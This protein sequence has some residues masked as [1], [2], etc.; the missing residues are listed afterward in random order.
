MSATREAVRRFE[1]LQKS[2]SVT[3]VPRP[4]PKVAKLQGRQIKTLA[5][6]IIETIL[7]G[8]LEKIP[9]IVQSCQKPKEDDICTAFQKSCSL[10][11][12]PASGMLLGEA[13]ALKV[14]SRCIDQ[15]CQG[16]ERA[17]TEE[18]LADNTP[19]DV[20]KNLLKD[21]VAG[22]KL[23]LI[24]FLIKTHRNL[25]QTDAKLAQE[26]LTLA[27]GQKCI[28]VI[29]LL[30]D[31]GASVT[32]SDSEGKQPLEVAV[33]SGELA[34]VTFVCQKGA[35]VRW[36][37]PKTGQTAM[38][39]AAHSGFHQAIL[40][41]A[42]CRANV[43]ELD[44]EGKSALYVA[45]AA[46][47]KEAVIALIEA[48]ADI[49]NADSQGGVTRGQTPFLLALEKGNDLIIDALFN[50]GRLD[51]NKCDGKGTTPLIGAAKVGNAKICSK[52]GQ[53]EAAVNRR[54]S[55]G[56]TALYWAVLNGHAQVVKEL[57]QLGADPNIADQNGQFPLLC[58]K[59]AA[60][61]EQLLQ[62]KTIEIDKID[63][64]GITALLQAT[65]K[66][67]VDIVRL[68]VAASAN[69]RKVC[70]GR[71]AVTPYFLAER[72]EN[73]EIL[74]IFKNADLQA[75]AETIKG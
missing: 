3:H 2:T 31:N 15:A 74:A 23:G 48:G 40:H 44:K 34:V 61:V 71:L 52:L 27:I 8:E 14:A 39:R 1:E 53:A 63:P 36:K 9:Q 43:D 56:K 24:E 60:V 35:N 25:I 42:S 65:E 55:S 22:S 20:I 11:N 7:L 5:D 73:H 28:P 66:R 54:D 37:D 58:A 12:V 47:S 67:R 72:A 68:L 49:N 50:S 29:T 75:V 4:I 30:L 16:K 38:H 45:V 17:F 64:S 51:F 59:S 41:L 69:Y 32:K 70:G 62:A 18:L 57:V 33:D 21:A 19:A 10:K 46:M 13:L 26:L 6:D